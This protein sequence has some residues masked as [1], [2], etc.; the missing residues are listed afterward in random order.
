MRSEQYM[1][2]FVSVAFLGGY[3]CTEGP[4][5]NYALADGQHFQEMFFSYRV[6]FAN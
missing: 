5:P 6:G 1:E 2:V 4:F 3:K